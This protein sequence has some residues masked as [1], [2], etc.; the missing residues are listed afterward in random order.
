[1]RTFDVPA[2]VWVAVALSIHSNTSRCVLFAL[3]SLRKLLKI[4]KWQVFGGSWGSCLG[5]TYAESVSLRACLPACLFSTRLTSTLTLTILLAKFDC[6]GVCLRFSGK[7]S[8]GG[9]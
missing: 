9:D 2:C 1:M 5:L 8:R 6:R 7:A 3:R 4:K